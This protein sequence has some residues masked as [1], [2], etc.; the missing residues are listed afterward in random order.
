LARL[1]AI[2]LA[3]FAIPPSVSGRQISI[4]VLGLYHPHQLE[5]RASEASL[6]VAIGNDRLELRPGLTED[7]AKLS[8]SGSQVVL[9]VRGHEYIGSELRA[10]TRDGTGVF[11]LAAQGRIA[12]E[13][14]G[15]L[16]VEVG[17]GELVPTVSM[18]LE[19]AVAAV[20][21]AESAPDAPLEALKAQA[22]VTRS[23]FAVGRGRHEN[24]DFCDLTHCQ[25]MRGLAGADSLATRAASETQGL[26][27][28]YKGKAFAAMFTRS[29][30]GRT[31]TTS[32]DRLPG[33]SY[34]YFAVRCDYCRANPVWW[35]RKLSVQDAATAA[36]GEAGRLAVNRKLGWKT[37]PSNSFVSQTE[38]SGITLRGTGQGHGIGLCQRGTRAMSDAGADFRTILRY[39]FPNTTLL[40][41]SQ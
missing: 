21:Q 26:V 11:S 18:D 6:A 36:K 39:Y 19:T 4:G 27:L 28:A 34:P 10:S 9:T 2:L 3:F 35:T 22:V 24:F 37:I 41:L 14:Q 23:Y 13:Y 40:N 1:F 16:L 30:G 29:C 15:L 25:V 20:V 38:A 7:V 5:L 32:E 17:N 31:R 33:G 12:R 8:A